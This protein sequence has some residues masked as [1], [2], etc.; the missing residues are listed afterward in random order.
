MKNQARFFCVGR[1]NYI[2][3]TNLVARKPA[4]ITSEV[5]RIIRRCLFIA[6]ISDRICVIFC[7]I[8]PIILRNNLKTPNCTHSSSG[9]RS[10]RFPCTANYENNMKGLGFHYQTGLFSQANLLLY[11]T[12][13]N[14]FTGLRAKTQKNLVLIQFSKSPILPATSD[15]CRKKK[16]QVQCELLSS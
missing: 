16:H 2:H 10:T 8:L 6:Q 4:I 14:K 11:S 5:N 15:F 13:G 12:Q 9:D 1:Y 7:P 3:F